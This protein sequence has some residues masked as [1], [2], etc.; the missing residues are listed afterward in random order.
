V[1]DVVQ[2]PLL[3]KLS[4]LVLAE[5]LLE[6]VLVV[7]CHQAVVEHAHALVSP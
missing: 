1:E 3:A 6:E 5:E 4:L 2:L 7:R